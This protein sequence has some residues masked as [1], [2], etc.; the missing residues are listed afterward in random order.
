MCTRRGPR[1]RDR[2]PCR[3][4]SSC[5]AG[6]LRPMSAIDRPTAGLAWSSSTASA[7]CRGGVPGRR[8]PRRR[9]DGRLP[10]RTSSGIAVLPADRARLASP[11]ACRPPRRRSPRASTRSSATTSR[12]IEPNATALAAPGVLRLLRLD[13]VGAGDPRRDA[14][15]GARPEPDAL[16]DV[17]ERAPSSSRSSSTGCAR[18]SGC[19]TSFDGL[20]TDTA[21]TSSLIAL[22]AARQAAGI[23]A[24]AAGIAGRSDVPALRVYASEEAHS[25]IDKAC[26]TLGLGPGVARPDPDERSLRA[27]AGRPRGCDRRRSRRRPPARSRS[28]RPSG[29]PRRPRS[30]RSPPIADIAAR[31]GLWLHVDAAYAGAVAIDP[32]LRG[33]VRAAGSGP[34]RSSSTRTS[35]SGRRS[36][37]R[38]C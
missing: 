4:A 28:S 22:A 12:L 1:P 36:T 19:P 18:R 11:L 25:S 24:A 26:M 8:P 31:E 2:P 7:T 16:A 3:G 34:T 6:R 37:P 14:G 15:R 38:C 21:S 20:L 33:A 17:A 30:T 29:R 10:R 27:R 23:D 32:E 13:R 5:R 35:G 9:P